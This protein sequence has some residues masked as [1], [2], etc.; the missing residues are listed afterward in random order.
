M[1]TFIAGT[2][3]DVFSGEFADAVGD[4][5]RSRYGFTPASIEEPYR[6]EPVNAAG[7]RDLQNLSRSMLGESAAPHL[8]GVD[9]YQAV[10]VPLP[11]TKVD[12]LQIANAADPLQVASL[13]ALIDH[14]TQFAARA[15]LP[16][17]D[18]ELMGLAADYL[19]SETEEKEHDVQ[20]YV[21][22]MLSAKQAV[23]RKQ[24][25]WVTT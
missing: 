5:L 3:S 22:L 9:A 23:A 19:E 11:L 20:V 17:D 15:S 25:L 1:L 8:T 12:H 7:W 18:L 21:Q 4:E 6:S 24:A 13:P 10:Y 16:T 2:A 14:L